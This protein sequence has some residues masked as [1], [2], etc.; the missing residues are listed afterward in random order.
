[1][2]AS[3]S[4]RNA[5][6][7][8]KIGPIVND[9]SG[10]RKWCFAEAGPGERTPDRSLRRRGRRGIV[11]QSFNPLPDGGFT[12]F[13]PYQQW[14]GIAKSERPITFYR[15]LGLTPQQAADPDAVDAAAAKAAKR[16]GEHKSGP[17][18]EVAARVLR[19]L[20]QARAILANEQKRKAYDAKLR[21]AAPK[22]AP[23]DDGFEVVD[24]TAD[25]EPEV[26]EAEVEEEEE[27][28]APTKKKRPKKAVEDE[29][30]DDEEAE[31]EKKK[32][33][34]MLFV[35]LGFGAL[36]L[37]L[38]G[39]GIAAYILL[40]KEEPKPVASNAAPRTEPQVQPAKP[41]EKEK[42]KSEQPKPDAPKPEAPKP[43]APK[44]EAPKPEPP[45][46][47]PAPKPEAP[48]IVKQPVPSADA[49]AKAE[50]GLKDAWKNDYAK[51]KP[52]D[53][54]ILAAKFLVPGR[55]DR[56][57][58]A[59]WYTLLREA[60][61]LAVE[62]KRPRL[63]F[64]AIADL[65]KYFVID[66][67]EMRLK[68]IGDMTK[69]APDAAVA[70]CFRATENL[71]QQAYSEE[72][73]DAG[74]K[75]LEA[76]EGP[77][78]QIQGEQILKR[79][80]ELKAEQAEL[81]REFESV[82]TA[83]EKLK[84]KADDPEANATVGR[85]L[86]FT[87]GDWDRGLLMLAKGS[88][89]GLKES[90]NKDLAQPGDVKGQLAVADAWWNWGTQLRDRGRFI[91]ERRARLW[92]D[93]AGATATG[94]ERQHV[95]NRL[96]EA[97]RHEIIRFQRLLPGSFYGRGPEDRVLLLREGGGNLQSE[98]A[99]ERGLEW[100]A[101]HQATNGHWSMNNFHKTAKCKCTEQG[102]AH[103][104]AGT[105]FAL[106]PFLGAGYTHKSTKY[107]GTVYRGAKWLLDK[108]NK[109][110]GAFDGNN[111]ENA[112]AAT[113]IIELY[114]MT[115][116]KD[117]A[118]QAQGAAN[119][120]ASAQAQD[121]SW[122]YAKAQPKGDLSVSGW[123]FTALKSAAYAGLSVPQETLDRLSQFL[124]TVEDKSGLGYGY[125]A[126][127]AGTAT[128]AVGLLCREFL[129][130]GPGHPGLNKAV[131]NLLKTENYLT[132]DKNNIYAAFYIMQVAHHLGGEHWQKW[133][134]AVRDVLI[135]F[136]DKGD[137]VPHQKGSWSP[138]GDTYAKQGGRLMYTA[139]SIIMLEAYYYHVPLYG[140]GP[141]VL[142]D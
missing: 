103:D 16:V 116:D 76:V 98:E 37:L 8:N 107:A 57:D 22:A 6:I 121:G 127:G 30:S 106:L 33:P 80:R 19:E 23:A 86:C 65:D 95:I 70:A 2:R 120:I 63:A 89:A 112:L 44:P 94:E 25:T 26:V 12:M 114:G 140:Y 136:Q 108:Q 55:E 125:N 115:K 132:K 29:E 69:A 45:K 17:H 142:L 68:A 85:Y 51:G 36:V 92:Y 126:P 56:N 77:V 124:D 35:A 133:N 101:A 58:P 62:A 41:T 111:Y 135:E 28:P 102:E 40:K 27:Q 104:V 46:P 39:G 74:K 78:R 67:V 59:A 110:D 134:N 52:E 87:Q 93:R 117:L 138:R 47:P 141:Y 49:Q 34:V 128:S 123:Q 9:E 122:N 61:D 54:T 113:V 7:E 42:A 97:Q 83:R 50:K 90:A 71:A 118:R 130:W 10:G 14:L 96:T 109:M 48:K 84:A 32:S 119:Y 99:V 81:A 66:A 3:F 13:D 139:L 137:S 82:K 21:Q 53:R 43:E 4:R 75:Y 73:F 105:A 18:A 88:A 11:Q 24:E 64:E 72:N 131:A 20:A 5:E 91:C 15:L 1:V 31:E 79:L 38:G 100:L 129:N 60:R